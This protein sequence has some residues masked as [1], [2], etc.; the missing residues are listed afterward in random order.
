MT[1]PSPTSRT[2]KAVCLRRAVLLLVVMLGLTTRV[3]GETPAAVRADEYRLKAAILYNIA[4]FVEW[5]AAAFA[6]AGSPI[7][8][9]VVGADPFG[10]GVLDE[11][12]RGRTVGA[13]SV[14]IRRLPEPAAG[15]HLVFIPYS[16]KK[17]VGDIIDRLKSSS[18]LTISEVDRF[19]EQGGII[20]LTTDGDRIRFDV[21]ASA[22][23]HAKL[24]VSARLMALASA[25]R[26]GGAP[27]Q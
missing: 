1:P 17:R 3:D 14:T 13:R 15:C 8:M 4:R 11:M 5:P 10:A 25:V 20:G 24:T 12:L 21:N 9:C 27:A 19:T 22:A 7:V 23:E 26:R 18:V 2:T 16:E 6:D